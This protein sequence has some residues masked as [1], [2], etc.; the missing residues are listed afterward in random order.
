VA[1]NNKKKIKKK[2]GKMWE[3]YTYTYHGGGV[4]W[5]TPRGSARVEQ[6]WNNRGTIA[7]S[8]EHFHGYPM[9]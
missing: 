4:G 9:P 6:S 5:C 8:V 3:Q 2:Q 1:E 7:A